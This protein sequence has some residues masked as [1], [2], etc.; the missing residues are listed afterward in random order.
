MAALMERHLLTIIWT[1]PSRWGLLVLLSTVSSHQAYTVPPV[2]AHL[3]ASFMRTSAFS[4][5]QTLGC[6]ADPLHMPPTN[7][8]SPWGDSA[9]PAPAGHLQE[10]PL[11]SLAPGAGGPGAAPGAEPLSQPVGGR[12]PALGG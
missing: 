5:L 4:V 1:R 10:G 7:P 3:Q 12:P 6:A 8:H 9:A 11:W 2:W